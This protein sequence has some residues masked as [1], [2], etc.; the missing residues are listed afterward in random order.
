MSIALDRFIFVVLF[1]IPQAVLLLVVMFVG[2]CGQPISSS[3]WRS[4]YA[5]QPVRK[6]EAYSAS[7]AAVTTVVMM[8][9]MYSMG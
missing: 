8:D 9:D 7:D 1:A 5:M 2:G 6:V 4:G 3:V